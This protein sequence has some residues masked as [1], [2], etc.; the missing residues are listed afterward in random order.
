MLPPKGHLLQRHMQGEVGCYLNSD[1][2]T[3]FKMW[4]F[5]SQV[6]SKDMTFKIIKACSLVGVDM[7]TEHAGFQNL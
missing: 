7:K 5:K 1:V 2:T 3:E 4:I 6:F